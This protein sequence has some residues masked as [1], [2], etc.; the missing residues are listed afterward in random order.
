MRE[1]GVRRHQEMSMGAD[2]IKRGGIGVDNVKRGGMGQM[3][4]R[5]E[6]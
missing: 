2:D 1:D 3:T 4:S 5:G 6:V